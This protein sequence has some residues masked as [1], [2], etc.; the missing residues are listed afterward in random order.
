MIALPSPTAMLLALG[1]LI[2]KSAGALTV[3]IADRQGSY[4]VFARC[5][6]AADKPK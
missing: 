5:K 2:D 6:D 1:A 3:S 4:V